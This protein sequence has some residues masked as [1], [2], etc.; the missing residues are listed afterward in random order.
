MSVR[1]WVSVREA[2]TAPG[3]FHTAAVGDK[4]VREYVAVC[5]I[6]VGADERHLLL[7]F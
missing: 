5:S 2:S 3:G 6:C 1:V 7:L 4:K